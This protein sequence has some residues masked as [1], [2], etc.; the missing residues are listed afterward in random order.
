MYRWNSGKENRY[1]R[2]RRSRRCRRV[3]AVDGSGTLCKKI[4][5]ILGESITTTVVVFVTPL[6]TIKKKLIVIIMCAFLVTWTHAACFTSLISAGRCAC[7]QQVA[8][9]R[10]DTFLFLIVLN[11]RYVMKVNKLMVHFR[12]VYSFYDWNLFIIWN[13]GEYL[14]FICLISF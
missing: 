12:L 10:E 7:L 11:S 6:L 3:R 1:V 9:C 4:C 2:R 14:T 8:H 5:R 13:N